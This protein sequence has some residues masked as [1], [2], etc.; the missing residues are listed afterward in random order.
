MG[1]STS[2]NLYIVKDN[3]L[4]QAHFEMSVVA[5]RIILL[6]ATDKFIDVLKTD[7]NA[8]IRITA[9]DYHDVYGKNLDT[10]PSYRAVRGVE[11]ELLDAKLRFKQVRDGEKGVWS[12]GINWITYSAYNH[13]LKC[14]ELSFSPQV[15]PLL[16]NVRRNF[17]YFNLRHIGMLRSMYSIRLYELIMMWRKKGQTPTLSVEYMKAYLG[18]PKNAYSEPKDVKMFTSQIIKSAVK[19]I[20]EKTNIVVEVELSKSGRQTVGYTF[21]HTNKIGVENSENNDDSKG[22]SVDVDGLSDENLNLDEDGLS[23]LPF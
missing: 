2:K 3:N 18:V 13:E 22:V 6:A 14:L 4:T 5:Y 19:E 21:S 16:F 7:Q 23:K 11:N 12:G 17:T 9:L 20:T 8:K 10:S 1:K 15:L